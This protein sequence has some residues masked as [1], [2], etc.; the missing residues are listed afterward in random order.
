MHKQDADF[1]AETH[2]C[3]NV[4]S[5]PITRN[6]PNVDSG[7]PRVPQVQDLCHC[8]VPPILLRPTSLLKPSLLDFPCNLSCRMAFLSILS[9]VNSLHRAHSPAKA[10]LQSLRLG[11]GSAFLCGQPAF[12][13][14]VPVVNNHRAMPINASFCL[15]VCQL[16]TIPRCML[17]EVTPQFAERWDICVSCRQ[18]TRAPNQHILQGQQRSPQGDIAWIVCELQAKLSAQAKKGS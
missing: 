9:R 13:Y 2:T 3:C 6:W 11:E 4:Y 8:Q 12:V 1:K 16:Q 10:K 18:K 17:E 5:H 15:N 7:R 14:A